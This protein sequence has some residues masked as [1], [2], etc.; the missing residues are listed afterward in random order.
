[1]VTPLWKPHNSFT[2]EVK[3]NTNS[4]QLGNFIGVF[5]A[6]HV[7][8]HTAIIRSIRCLVAAFGFMHCKEWENMK[9]VCMCVWC[10][11]VCVWCVYVCVWCV[12]N[13]CVCVC[14][15]GVCVCVWGVYV[16]CVC[17]LCVCCVCVCVCVWSVRARAC[18]HH[19]IYN[20]TLLLFQ[21]SRRLSQGAMTHF[22]SRVNKVFCFQASDCEVPASII[23]VGKRLNLLPQ[24]P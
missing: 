3:W 20:V 12:C 2:S 4:M 14:V 18:Q 16:V 8:V 13:V 19:F 15:C 22:M 17:A 24:T 7:S 21:P 5:L 11:Y 1:M 9:C 6:R 23:R 10:V